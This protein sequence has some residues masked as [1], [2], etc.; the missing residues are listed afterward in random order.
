[1]NDFNKSLSYVCKKIYEPAG[2]VVQSME[3]EK[4][5]EKY[6][7]GIFRLSATSIR[8]RVAKIT[9]NKIGQ[10]VAIWEKDDNN[11]NQ[12]FS[13]DESPDFL[14]VTTFNN[15]EHFGQF[16]FP[17]TLL[18]EKGIVSG[19]HSK[20][21]M[22]IRVYPD[23]DQPNNEQALNTKKW[24]EQYFVN[25]SEANDKTISRLKQLYGLKN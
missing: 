4:Q 23:W 12:P 13:F 7:A 8:F 3:E 6:G 11:K 5:N 1:M 14:V 10:F 25:F 18:L 22:G 21:K 2:F 15:D 16:I 9:P 20:G 19:K 17:K 24:Q